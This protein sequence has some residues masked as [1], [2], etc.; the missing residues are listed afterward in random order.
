MKVIAVTIT[1]NRESVIADALLS[2]PWADTILIMD[3]GVTDRTLNIAQEIAG[4]RLVIEKG[5]N[6]TSDMSAWRNEALRAAESLG[7]NF[8]CMLDTDVRILDNGVDIRRA[9][10][11]TSADVIN[12]MENSGLYQKELFFRLP[13]GKFSGRYHEGFQAQA[14][15]TI[16]TLNRVR[17][18]ELPKTAARITERLTNDVIGLRKQLADNPGDCRSAYY[19]GSTYENLGQYQEAIAAY[20][21]CAEL[22]GPP[23]ERAWAC[24]R[25][26]SCYVELGDRQAA[27][28]CCARGMM[29]CPG[30]V[31]LPW[32]AGVQCLA[33]G[34]AYDAVHWANIAATMGYNTFAAS[35]RMGFRAPQ[36]WFEGPSEI[37]ERALDLLGYPIGSTAA[38][39][40]AEQS[41]ID[42]IK[43]QG[44]QV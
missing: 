30:M 38:Q 33:V 31:E 28:R 20:S 8:A 41:R 12:V 7:G 6:S 9:L 39:V 35:M 22:H 3:Y 40:H 25:A 21:T 24:F 15:A 37:L 5:D 32:F 14:Q 29:L 34:R 10:E 17:F 23:E 13:T 11:E 43:W 27:I 16:G 26:A 18:Y 42:R 19:L 2:A 4:D 36:A 44:G 1:S